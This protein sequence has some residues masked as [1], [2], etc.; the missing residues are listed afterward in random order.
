MLF[1]ILIAVAGVALLWKLAFV[2]T[3]DAGAAWFGT[4]ATAMATPIA[5]HSFT[6]YPDSPA[7]VITLTGVW[8]LMRLQGRGRRIRAR[9]PQLAAPWRGA[10]HLPWLHTRFAFLA[11][12]FGLFILAEAAE[13]TRRPARGGGVHGGA[14]R[15]R[16]ALVLVLLCDLRDSGPAGAVWERRHVRRH[17]S[18][19]FVLTGLL[20]VLFDQQFGLFLYAPVFFVALGGWMAAL[21]TRE[22]P[23]NRRLAIDLAISRGT[24]PVRGHV[25][26]DVVGG[27]ERTGPSHGPAPD[28]G[29]PLRG[30]RVAA[31]DASAGRAPPRWRRCSSRRSPR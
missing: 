6:V 30:G 23:I 19:P 1:L 14:R 26:A 17:A 4:C 29:R 2:A 21:G 5:F 20:G 27:L 11:A 10:R 3:G 13:N 28:D 15:E 22:G 25:S 31:D 16:R 12:L 18:L 9:D 7:W 24:L 8:A